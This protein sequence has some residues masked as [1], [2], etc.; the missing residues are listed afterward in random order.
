M[1][2][3]KIMLSPAEEFFYAHAGYSYD[4][5]RGETPGSGRVRTA[6]LLAAAEEGLNR[7][8]S[9]VEWEEDPEPYD[10]DVPY[11]GPMWIATLRNDSGEVLASLGAIATPGG[12]D[13][14]YARVIAAELAQQVGL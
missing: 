11:D 12:A 7:S 14:D 5:A 10:G 2:T 3:H 6:V 4:P 13:D 8:D 1:A 9:Y